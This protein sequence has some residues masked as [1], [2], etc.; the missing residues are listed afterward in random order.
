MTQGMMG[1]TDPQVLLYL[2][3][4][5]THARETCADATCPGFS[6]HPNLC[7][8]LFHHRD[9]IPLLLVHSKF[10]KNMFI[11]ERERESM[12]EGGTGGGGGGTEDPKWALH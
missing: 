9:T 7:I 6:A 12:R 8:M 10:F 4:F 3:S 5:S 2:V 11:F 1:R